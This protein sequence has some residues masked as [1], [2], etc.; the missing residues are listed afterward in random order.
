VVVRPHARRVLIALGVALGIAIIVALGRG[1]VGLSPGEVIAALGN[2]LGL[3]LGDTD[4]R[5]L[6]I[7]WSVRM[8]RVVLALL[9]GAALACSGA[10]LQGVAR[11]ALADPTLVGV[12]GGAALGA[13][14][15]IVLGGPLLA[16]STFGVWLVPVAAFGGALLSTRA[17]LAIARV[18]GATSGVT[19]LLAGI[20]LAALA[21]SGVGILLY[22]ADDAALRSVTFWSLGSVGG[23]TWTLVA[24]VALPIGLAVVWLPRLAAELDRLALGELEARHVG[25]DV[26][27]LIRRVT[28]LAALA[29]GAAVA[30]CGSIAFVGLVVPYL[31]RAIL[32]PGHRSLLPACALGGAVLLV[33]AD[34]IA[35][36]IVAPA[37]LPIGVITALAG[38]PVLLALVRRGR[39]GTAM[40]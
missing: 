18:G 36:T 24:A 15:A 30:A 33:V 10:A 14:T 32:G 7:V 13:V 29:V 28:G 2:K 8:P 5:R 23:A 22:L 35:R 26:D 12:S 21:G 17:A 37:E 3:D 38:A 31:A 20:G 19:I 1:A 40:P 27:R 4:D 6:A 9:V 11:N 16:H 25:V 39:G 34:L